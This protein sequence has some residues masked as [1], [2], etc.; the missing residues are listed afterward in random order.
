VRVN[1]ASAAA[2]LLRS[3]VI[4][5]MSLLRSRPVGRRRAGRT[6]PRATCVIAK[7]R[8]Q[9]ARQRNKRT[10][11]TVGLCLCVAVLHSSTSE[12]QP[13]PSSHSD[14]AARSH[15]IISLIHRRYCWKCSS[16]FSA[17]L[18]GFNSYQLL[19]T[20]SLSLWIAAGFANCV[21]SNAIGI[22]HSCKHMNASNGLDTLSYSKQLPRVSIRNLHLKT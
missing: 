22:Q 11:C 9:M 16:R 3:W 14:I 18:L 4:S 17:C 20:L 5:E 7:L 21:S 1:S 12:P 2:S 6:R 15:L 8:A 13:V 10:R 19:L